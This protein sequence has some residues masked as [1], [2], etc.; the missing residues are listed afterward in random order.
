MMDCGRNFYHHTDYGKFGVPIEYLPPPSDVDYFSSP[1]GLEYLPP[2][3]G[4]GTIPSRRRLPAI[5][6][7][8]SA[9]V[10]HAVNPAAKTDTKCSLS[11]DARKERGG[12][13]PQYMRCQRSEVG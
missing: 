13:G 6:A 7:S 5:P 11:V 8:V 9:I 4:T 3:A 2:P 1:T 12:G 10:C